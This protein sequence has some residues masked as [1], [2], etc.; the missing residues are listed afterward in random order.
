MML[1]ED[2]SKSYLSMVANHQV[3]E[4]STI[5]NQ[6]IHSFEID[7]FWLLNWLKF[8]LWFKWLIYE[9]D[10]L[11]FR[12]KKILVICKRLCKSR[13]KCYFNWLGYF[14][15]LLKKQKVSCLCLCLEWFVEIYVQN[16]Q[17][18]IVRDV[19]SLNSIFNIFPLA[20]FF[21]L[22]VFLKICPW[23]LKKCFIWQEFYSLF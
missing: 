7:T 5:T 6:I 17:R 22:L 9:N 1:F 15:Y 21:K 10:C 18:D 3:L 2:S 4:N 20:G 23:I 16:I 14:Y 11:T 13:K 19:I 12:N 8:I